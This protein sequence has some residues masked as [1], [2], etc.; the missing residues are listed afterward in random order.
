LI[1]N[2]RVFRYQDLKV[3]WCTSQGHLARCDF[4]VKWN[5]EILKIIPRWS[6]KRLKD[7]IQHV[8]HKHHHVPKILGRKYSRVQVPNKPMKQ[9]GNLDRLF[10]PEF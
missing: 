6:Y 3:L 10:L 4:T 9:L 2:V 5:T 8:A 1:V 7:F